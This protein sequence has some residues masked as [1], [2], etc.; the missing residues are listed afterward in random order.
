MSQELKEAL[1]HYVEVD[2][3]A[4]NAADRL[5][6]MGGRGYSQY[7]ESEGDQ[8]L[9]WKTGGY[10]TLFDILLVTVPVIFI[11]VFKT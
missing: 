9:K 4:S 10:K 11:R 8:A 7:E 6:D 5:A 3:G 2:E 1:Q